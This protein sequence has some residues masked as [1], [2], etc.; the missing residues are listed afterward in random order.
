MGNRVRLTPNANE[1]AAHLAVSAS[2]TGLKSIVFV[3]TK[4]DAITVAA[5][6]SEAISGTIQPTQLEQARWQALEKELGDLKHAVIAGPAIAVPH[7]SAMLRLERDLCEGMFKRAD[8][9]RTIVA[10]PTLAQGLNLPAHLAILAGDKRADAE[11][12]EAL[13][14]HEILNAA[15]RAGRAGHLANGLVLLIPEPVISFDKIDTLST[16]TVEKLRS[17]LPEDDHC[18]VVADPLE[19]VLDRLME[20]QVTDPDVQYTVNR[21]AVVRE[22]EGGS[23]EPTHLFDLNKS[24]GAYLAKKSETESTFKEKV[25]GFKSAITAAMPGTLDSATAVLA[26]QSG[27]SAQLLMDLRDRIKD[28]IGELPTTIDGWL[29]WTVLWLDKDVSARNALFRDVSKSILAMVGKTA[30]QELAEGDVAKL[31]PG[32]RAWIT[33]KPIRQIE[34]EL[35]GAPDAGSR[36]KRLCPRA[37]ELVGTLI[38]RSLSFTLGLVSKIVKDVNPFA[39]QPTLSQQTIEVLGTAV[40]KGYDTPEKLFYAG[41]HLSVLSRVQMHEQFAQ[42]TLTLSL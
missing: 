37:R 28:E 6:I 39:T 8:G 34:I 12:R 15:A 35:G 27:L 14:A 3:N 4:A 10:T 36:T 20:G 5:A 13:K 42:Q 31:L 33:G 9:A 38:P 25:V 11:G 17:I 24:L 22:V 7:N 2:N 40:R 30:K 21:F 19:I 1:V 16:R 29:E 23:E 41:E 32:I 26:T 18:V